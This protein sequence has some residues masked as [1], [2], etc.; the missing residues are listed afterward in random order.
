MLNCSQLGKGCLKQT[1]VDKGI[2]L[3]V[4]KALD[5]TKAKGSECK[6]CC[7]SCLV[8]DSRKDGSGPEKAPT[9]EKWRHHHI[10]IGGRTEQC[11]S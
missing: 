11:T 6:Q 7:Y 1:T 10:Q 8:M 3:L 4:C 5:K 9:G 2:H